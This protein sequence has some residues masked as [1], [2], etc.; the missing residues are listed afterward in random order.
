[1]AKPKRK[2]D[3]IAFQIDHDLPPRVIELCREDGRVMVAIAKHYLKELYDYDTDESGLTTFV[4]GEYRAIVR[5]SVGASCEKG[6]GR[7]G[8]VTKESFYQQF[9]FYLVPDI[10]GKSFTFKRRAK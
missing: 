9:D 10:R 7:E 2:E 3:S 8:V 4:M 1:M 5:I 6:V